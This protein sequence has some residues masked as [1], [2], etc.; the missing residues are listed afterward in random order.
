M[1][2]KTVL[3]I[4]LMA[5]N[6]WAATQF[7][8]EPKN[9]SVVFQAVGNPDFLKIEGKGLGPSGVV[10]IDGQTLSG[11][12]SFDLASLD[13][14]IS[15]RDEH[16]KEKYLK[17]AQHPRSTLKLSSLPLSESFDPQ[18]NYLKGGELKG[19]LTLNGV[20]KD[21]TGRWKAERDGKEQDVESE[22][23]IKLSDFGIEIPSFAG[24]TVADEVKLL[25]N[26]GLSPAAN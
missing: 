18:K 5:S 17:V 16:M 10:S 23:K 22:F 1:N 8:A 15:K 20:T 26:A 24:V 4:G 25:V 9:G 13:T 6:S 2:A 7:K 21:V 19:Q 14:G 11:E 12:L 3:V